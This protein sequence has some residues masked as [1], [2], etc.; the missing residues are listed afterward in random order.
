MAGLRGNQAWIMGQKQPSGNKGTAATVIAPTTAVAGAYKFPLTGGGIGPRRETDQ[1]SE[2]DSSRDQGTSFV[3]S[4]GVEGS[5]E[6][7]VRDTGIGFLLDAVL[8]STASSGTTPRTHVH[9]PADSLKYFTFWRMLGGTLYERF[10][11]C[12]VGSLTIS[13]EAGAP[14]TATAGIQGL[15]PTRLAADPST[16]PAIA[17]QSGAVFSFNDAAVT[18]AGGATALVR[19]FELSIENNL[20]SQQ[21]DDVVPYDIAEGT[22]EV[23]LSFDLIFETLAQYNEFHY[24]SAGGYLDVRNDI[25]TTNAVFTFT[26][27]A[28]SEIS[29]NLPSLAITEFPVEASAGGDPIVVSVAA[30]AQ[31]SGSPVVTATV[32]NAADVY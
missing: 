25:Y 8:G 18:L 28:N 16:A 14:L 15:V 9:T 31:R 26:K 13:A 22:R 27:S 3:T 5:P 2:T 30:A 4:S 1:L 32:K 29:F 11:D 12:K 10:Q 24:K 6:V 21:T 17:L 7:Y 20:T 23:S 19:S